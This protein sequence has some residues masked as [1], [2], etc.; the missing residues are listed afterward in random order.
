MSNQAD[1]EKK[2]IEALGHYRKALAAVESQEQAEAS[3]Q[4]ALTGLLPDLECAIL[5]DCAPSVKDNLFRTG[6]VAISRSNEAWDALSKATTTLEVARQALVALERQLGYIPGVSNVAAN[7]RS[8]RH[9][10]NNG[11]RI[12]GPEPRLTTCCVRRLA[13]RRAGR[14]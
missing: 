14:R 3:A 2:T 9:S 12:S 6:L 10:P 13:Y 1:L 7:S 8:I 5:E 11:S 4:R